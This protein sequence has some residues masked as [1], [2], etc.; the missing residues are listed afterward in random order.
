MGQIL[1][2][3]ADGVPGGHAEKP[4]RIRRP[5]SEWRSHS[6]SISVLITFGAARANAN[7]TLQKAKPPPAAAD[8]VI[9]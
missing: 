3:K 1:S 6:S 8:G 7:A 5:V 9:G 4:R 2:F